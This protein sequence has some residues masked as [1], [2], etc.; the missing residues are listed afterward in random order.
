[1]SHVSKD[2]WVRYVHGEHPEEVR[3]KYEDHLYNC[4]H[5][6]ELY[7]QAME[8]TSHTL[9][10]LADNTEITDVIMA[11][12]SGEKE[13][14]RLKKRPFYEKTAFHYVVAAA[15]TVILMSSGVF[16]MIT[17]YVEDVQTTTL[18]EQAPSITEQLLQIL[19]TNEEQ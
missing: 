11:Q 6:M 18:S 15:M 9:P 17:N 3:M 7:L 19:F 16:Q 13:V 8:D 12:I 2:D 10:Q 5:C 14:E 1:M 4:D